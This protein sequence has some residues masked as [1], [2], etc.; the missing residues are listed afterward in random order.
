M[1]KTWLL[2]ITSRPTSHTLVALSWVRMSRRRVVGLWWTQRHSKAT[3][4]NEWTKVA[5]SL[6]RAFVSLIPAFCSYRYLLSFPDQLSVKTRSAGSTIRLETCYFRS[7]GCWALVLKALIL[8]PAIF[9]VDNMI[10]LRKSVLEPILKF[11]YRYS[12]GIYENYTVTP[13]IIMASPSYK[14]ILNRY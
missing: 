4:M 2:A 3:V 1:T 8:K 10:L 13:K 14:I 11:I 12:K 6:R 5:S 9:S 7:A